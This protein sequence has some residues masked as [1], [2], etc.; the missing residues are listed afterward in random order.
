VRSV[1]SSTR[2]GIEQ[3]GTG[4]VGRGQECGAVMVEAA[5]VVVMLVALIS[6]IVDVGSL[7]QSR[8]A[9]E[10]LVSSAARATTTGTTSPPSDLPMLIGIGE[11]L[12]AMP[13]VV[14]QRIVVFRSESTLGE[15][16]AQCADVWP[17]GTSA[18]GIQGVCNVYGPGHVDAL[19]AG[20]PYAAGCSPPSWEALWC[21]ASRVRL[22]SG[23]DHAGVFVEVQHHPAVSGPFTATPRTLTST[24]VAR[25]EPELR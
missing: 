13:G 18:T 2:F 10:R 7:A 11:S 25:L 3:G 14:L 4:R 16:P 12:D 24:T 23:A 8:I 22:A 19:R 21:P 5:V 6:G 9:L 17:A 1:D 20:Q 15:L